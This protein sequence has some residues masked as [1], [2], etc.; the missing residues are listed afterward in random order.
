MGALTV[1]SDFSRGSD[2]ALRLAAALTRRR[3]G[4]LRVVHAAGPASPEARRATLEE[5]AARGLGCP[6]E[7]HV[8]PGEPV[9][10]LALE[11]EVVVGA[12]GA[13]AT[14]LPRAGHVPAALALAGP[15][16]LFVAPLGLPRPDRVAFDRLLV[17]CGLDD[18]SRDERLVEAAC[19]FLRGAAAR[20]ALHLVH[21]VPVERGLAP[22]ARAGQVAS[23][24]PARERLRAL[25]EGIPLELVTARE[26]VLHVVAQGP[27]DRDLAGLAESQGADL[28][29]AGRGRTAA[30]LVALARCPLLVLG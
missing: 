2:A 4:P 9:D 15:R 24:E 12:E 6:A 20:A 26:P 10:V 13:S 29:I 1:G 11:D 19:G 27:V 30:R 18:P 14:L 21:V 22:G 25:A 16:R 23:P 7:S 3:P 5:Q 17:A 28:L 8:A